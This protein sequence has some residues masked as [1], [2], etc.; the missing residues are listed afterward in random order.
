MRSGKIHFNLNF[1]LTVTFD[2]PQQQS[3]PG[4][5][6][7]PKSLPQEWKHQGSTPSMHSN[8]W[9]ARPTLSSD[10]HRYK[11]WNVAVIFLENL[12]P[13]TSLSVPNWCRDWRTM[14]SMTYKPGTLYSG[15]HCKQ[16]RD[17][18]SGRGG[19][20]S[21][22]PCKPALGLKHCSAPQPL[23]LPAQAWT[24]HPLEI[25]IV[26]VVIHYKFSTSRFL[27]CCREGGK[28]HNLL[29]SSPP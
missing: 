29:I 9:R 14:E 25:P 26:L 3:L 19:A 1:H 11:Y 2:N 4:S 28:S 5:E 12:G 18:E 24:L 17:P 15:L 23:P 7:P 10:G 27:S 8:T 6:R 16:H 20:P 13:K 21:E 22:P